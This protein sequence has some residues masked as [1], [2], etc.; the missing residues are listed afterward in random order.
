M[1]FYIPKDRETAER[2][3]YA[4]FFKKHFIRQC[5][6]TLIFAITLLYVYTNYYRQGWAKF[7]D[8][9][10]KRKSMILSRNP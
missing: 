3:H 6:K 10:K 4:L 9:F 1:V 8:F 5:Y 7:D 2:L